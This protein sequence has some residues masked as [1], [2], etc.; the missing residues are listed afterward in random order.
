MH[1]TSQIN[2]KPTIK[3]HNST[4]SP[5]ATYHPFKILENPPY[6]F[7][8][9]SAR[10][11]RA[12][13]RAKER[14]R[15]KRAGADLRSSTVHRTRGG[16]Q[17]KKQRPL[18]PRARVKGAII[19]IRRRRSRAAPPRRRK[20]RAHRVRA[21]RKLP[22]RRPGAQERGPGLFFRPRSPVHI[23]SAVIKRPGILIEGGERK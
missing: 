1:A 23:Y 17:S 7:S 21:A 20:R 4:S 14:R 18:L 11:T 2:T 19:E 3:I 10:K 6:P 5:P 16:R 9:P 15:A 13:P 12:S 8:K 22:F